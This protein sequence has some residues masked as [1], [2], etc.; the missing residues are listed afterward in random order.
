MQEEAIFLQPSPWW[1]DVIYLPTFESVICFQ[2]LNHQG[3]N[4]VRAKSIHFYGPFT[5]QL[6]LSGRARRISSWCPASIKRLE[7]LSSRTI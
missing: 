6:R 7:D 4:S 3:C 1:T 2:D 5:Y